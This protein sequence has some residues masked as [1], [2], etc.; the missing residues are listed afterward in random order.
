MGRGP[1][2]SYMITLEDKNVI[3]EHYLPPTMKLSTCSCTCRIGCAPLTANCRIP[4]PAMLHSFQGG[5][6]SRLIFYGYIN[7][8][9]FDPSVKNGVHYAF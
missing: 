6:C 2:P 9:P 4:L 8:D 1:H 5:M 7:L 3:A